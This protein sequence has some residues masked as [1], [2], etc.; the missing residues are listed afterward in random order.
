MPETQ[1]INPQATK[2]EPLPQP[3]HT[4]VVVQ[5]TQPAQQPQK[6]RNKGVD[7]LAGIRGMITIVLIGLLILLGYIVGTEVVPSVRQWLINHN[8]IE[9]VVSPTT[10]DSVIAPI[11][12]DQVTTMSVADI[13]ERV[14][15]AVVSIAVA[16]VSLE[17]GSGV[18]SST[19]NIGTG[20]IIDPAGVIVTNQ[21]VV[22]DT[23]A[24]YQVVTKDNKVLTPSK[25]VRDT[26]NDVAF[27]FVDGQS[28]QALTMGDS[29]KLRVGETV[30]AIGT[31]LGE[32]PG[33]VTTGVISGLKRT[34]QTGGSFWGASRE[35][36]NVIQTD[37]AVN[38]GNSGGP[39]INS[40]GEV[41]GV[42]FATT[43]GADNIS[44]ALPIS[45]VKD[46]L[47]EY[48]QYGRLRAAYL[49][50]TYSLLSASQAKVYGLPQGA[51]VRSVVSGSPAAE[52]GIQRGDVITKIADQAVSTTF[53]TQIQKL[54]IG[55]TIDVVIWRQQGP[56]A[57]GAEQTVKLKVGERQE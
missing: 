37:A 55:S 10:T 6:P 48:K 4:P 20:F 23:T 32:F 26:F 42:N 12:T 25:I 39:L 45:L 51:L 46:R 5:P 13:V 35:Y 31:P 8:F 38:P 24:E 30:I 3:V 2:K 36:E 52:A 11:Q 15:P 43:S 7:L 33:S 29:D 19:S 27:V 14:S 49:G 57:Q 9:S 34:V 17:E 50:V 53:A 54:T 44:F 41:V 40:S 47:A 28:L 16:D 22:S 1:I 18:S 21:H 56:Q